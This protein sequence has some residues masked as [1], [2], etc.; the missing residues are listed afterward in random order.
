MK[1]NFKKLFII[2]GITVLSVFSMISVNAADSYGYRQKGSAK[3]SVGTAVTYCTG[4]YFKT[5]ATRW[6]TFW[7]AYSD[8]TSLK[9][10]MVASSKM[11]TATD[12]V[13]TAEAKISMTTFDYRSGSGIS[14]LKFKNTGSSVVKG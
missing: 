6:K 3:S 7:E 1:K 14:T 8:S 4:T 12:T 11:K 2:L 13:M 9:Q 5:G 10:A